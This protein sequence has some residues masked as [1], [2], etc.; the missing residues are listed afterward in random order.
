VLNVTVVSPRASGDLRVFP[1]QVITPHVSNLNFR[2][3]QTVAN[4]VIVRPINGRINL[5]LD[6][7]SAV[8]VDVD[9]TGYIG[10][11]LG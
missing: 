10:P 9:V 11:S 4:A 6:S 3:G 5:Y 8:A 2:P 1:Q 7:S